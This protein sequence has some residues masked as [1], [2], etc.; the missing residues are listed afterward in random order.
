MSKPRQCS[1]Y[2]MVKVQCISSTRNQVEIKEIARNQGNQEI[3]LFPL[4]HNIRQKMIVF[5]LER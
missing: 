2:T 1:S 4:G 3:G 5:V